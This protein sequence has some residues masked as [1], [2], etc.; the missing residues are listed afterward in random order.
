M[1]QSKPADLPEVFSEKKKNLQECDNKSIRISNEAVSC[2]GNAKSEKNP[3]SDSRLVP[4][5]LEK[6]CAT[7]RK[8][9]VIN[10]DI[11]SSLAVDDEQKVCITLFF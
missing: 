10:A 3:I 11:L 7:D 5:Q 6:A 1:K 4:A 2:D 8:V 9:F